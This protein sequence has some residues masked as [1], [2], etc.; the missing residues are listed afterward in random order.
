[1]K[2]PHVKN[3][4][5]SCDYSQVNFAVRISQTFNLFEYSLEVFGSGSINKIK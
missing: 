4:S 1:M 2:C 3:V 5:E